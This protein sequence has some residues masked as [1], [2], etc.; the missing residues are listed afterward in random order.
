MFSSPYHSFHIPVLGISFTIDT[1]IKVARYQ[2]PQ[3][4]EAID[5]QAN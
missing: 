3:F 2:L 4:N 5:R 1:P